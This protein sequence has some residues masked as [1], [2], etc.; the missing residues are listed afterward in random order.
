MCP[1]LLALGRG[2]R[3]RH[4]C[5]ACRRGNRSGTA[6]GSPASSRIARETSVQYSR[7]IITLSPGAGPQGRIGNP[8]DLGGWTPVSSPAVR[9]DLPA[10]HAR[11]P[12]RAPWG[13]QSGESA[14]RSRS[15]TPG[16]GRDECERGGAGRVRA[17]PGAAERSR[18]EPSREVPGR[19]RQSLPAAPHPSCCVSRLGVSLPLPRRPQNFYC[20]GVCDEI[21]AL[22]CLH[23]RLQRRSRGRA[24]L[25]RR[26]ALAPCASSPA[27][28]SRESRGGTP[29]GTARALAPRNPVH[30]C[31]PARHNFKLIP[32]AHPGA[33]AAAAAAAVAAVS[34]RA[35]GGKAAQA[36]GTGLGAA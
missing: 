1:I 5:A 29:K 32:V 35:R 28:R 23:A 34:Q 16:A 36:T 24:T 9:L 14:T 18:A 6:P 2:R 31:G 15:S 21:A 3:G 33:P 13:P 19:G 4:H 8:L 12:Q 11:P 27:D 20:L 30:R 25:A 26:R 7:V 22:R 10:A 17:E